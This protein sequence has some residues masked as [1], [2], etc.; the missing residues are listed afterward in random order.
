MLDS[1][2]NERKL[3]WLLSLRKRDILTACSLNYSDSRYVCISY[4]IYIKCDLQLFKLF[5]ANSKNISEPQRGN[6]RWDALTMNNKCVLFEQQMC[7]VWTTNVCC[8]N[9][10]CVLFEQQMCVVWTTNVCSLNNK[11]VLFEQQMCCLNYKCVLFELQM[12][13]LNLFPLAGIMYWSYSSL[14]IDQT[15]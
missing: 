1:N 6:L 5:K 7:V 15:L 2:G 13:C 3:W 8:L 11:C 4:Q 12:Y 9:N 14:S 10:K